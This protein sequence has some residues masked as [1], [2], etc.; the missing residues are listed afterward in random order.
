MAH[1][2]IHRRISGIVTLLILL[3]VLAACGGQQASTPNPGSTITVTRVDGAATLAR[4]STGE[5]GP[6]PDSAQLTSGD[7]LYTKATEPV[8][9]QFPDGSTLHV[10]PDSHLLLYTVNPVD[11][12]VVFRVLSGAVTAD[13]RGMPLEMQAYE[14]VAQNFSMM[15]TDLALIPR[16]SGGQYRLSIDNNTLQAVITAGEFDVRSDNQQA[17]LPAGWQASVA[18]GQALQIKSLVTP[19][20]APVSA[21]DAPTATPIIIITI[22][23]TRTP[24]N[25][26]TPTLS[27]TPTPTRTRTPVI[28]RRTAT[29]TLEPTTEVT[30]VNAIPTVTQKPDKQPKPTNPPPATNPPQ[31]TKEATKEP[32]EPPR[33]TIAGAP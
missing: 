14:E 10:E 33:P 5:Q 15:A 16:G 8:T 17:T 13:V 28:I 9:L 27:R 7:H 31:P 22:T 29:S 21:T 18:P 11:R 4:P 1:H 3:L 19:T 24:P 12:A 25:T 26:P 30:V 20:L 32:T 23:P 6:L 2:V